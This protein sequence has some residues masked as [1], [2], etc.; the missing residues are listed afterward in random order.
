MA[1]TVETIGELIETL[2]GPT[3]AAETLGVKSAQRVVNW[4]LRNKITPDL[5]MK[6]QETLKLAGIAAPASFWFGGSA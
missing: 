1:K 2:G 4:R 5:F 3:K 6:H